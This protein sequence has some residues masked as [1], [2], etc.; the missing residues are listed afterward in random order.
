MS[1]PSLLDDTDMRFLDSFFDGV[2]S[3]EYLVNDQYNTWNY[4]WQDLPPD[5]LGTTSSFGPQIEPITNDVLH[6]TFPEFKNS[7]EFLPDGLSPSRDVIATTSLLRNGHSNNNNY[8]Q[9]HSNGHYSNAFIAPTSCPQ[10]ISPLFHQGMAKP[11]QHPSQQRKISTCPEYYTRHASMSEAIYGGALYAP[12]A[13]FRAR[14]QKEVDIKW[15]SDSGFNTG[16]HF[17]APP[18]TKTQDEIDEHIASTLGFLQPGSNTSTCPSS[19]TEA[20]H[21][22][23]HLDRMIEVISE[24]AM[25]DIDDGGKGPKKRKK[26]KGREI[27]YK[28]DVLEQQRQTSNSAAKL[29]RKRRPKS[30]SAAGESQQTR[31]SPS[32]HKHL[33]PKLGTSLATPKMARKNL[34]KDQ[35]QEKH[36][37]S[38]QKRR[39]IIKKGF[40]DLNDLVPG[41]RGG[42]SLSKSA[43]LIIAANW[44]EELVRRNE[45][46]RVLIVELEGQWGM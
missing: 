1:G 20:K 41:L 23:A 32:L 19:P 11:E 16:Q 35:K 45:G 22:N 5:F 40:E 44:L 18:N 2:S 27:V 38:E 46:F 15:G 33:K 24:G 4:E 26:N 36:I 8:R 29:P 42:G 13:T 21:P 30:F 10:L 37:K 43:M 12:S 28:S 6:P 25:D 31:P 39:T 34:T 3:G 17:V 9:T 14:A 7:L